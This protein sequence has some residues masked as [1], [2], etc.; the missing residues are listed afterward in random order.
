[1]RDKLIKCDLC[2]KWLKYPTIGHHCKREHGP[3]LSKEEWENHRD[4]LMGRMSVD[5]IYSAVTND[6]SNEYIPPEITIYLQEKIWAA[7]EDCKQYK[8]WY[9]FIQDFI[10]KVI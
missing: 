8:I 5:L 1:M 7:F 2:K 10:W 6:K 4:N 9:P 3:L